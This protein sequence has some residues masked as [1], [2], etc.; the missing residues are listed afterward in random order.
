MPRRKRTAEP[1]ALE[2]FSDEE[3]LPEDLESEEEDVEPQPEQ[4][5]LA[6]EPLFAALLR[7]AT[8]KL[9]PGD[10]VMTDFVTH[11]AGPLSEL[12]GTRGAKGGDF[13][14]KRVQAGLD[15]EEGYSLDQSFRAHLINGLFP[16]LHVAHWL[17]IWG[18]PRLRYLNDQ[19]RRLFMAGYVLHDWLKLPDVDEELRAAGLSH[20]TVNAKQHLTL[21]ETL[22]QHWCEKLGLHAFL[23]PVGGVEVVLH[24]L[25]YIACNTQVKWGTLRNLSALPKLS[26]DGRTLDVCESLSRLADLITYVAP[27][28]R[29][30]VAHGGIHRE[31]AELSN[32]TARLV[33]HHV[34]DNRGVLTNL[35]HN[36]ALHAMR[37]QTR[38]PFL[39]A[40]SGVV[41]LQ[42]VSAPPLPD[43][44]TITEATIERVR[45]V[46][47]QRLRL[48]LTGFRRDG[49]G[50][51][52]ADYYDLFFDLS[53]QIRLAAAAIF[54]NIPPSKAP[55]AGKRFTKMR[56]GSWLD[57]SVDLALPDDTRVDQLA[58]WCYYV[59]ALLGSTAPDFDTAEFLMGALRLADMRPVFE[60][61]PR[62]NR[63]GGVGYHWYFM[64]GHYLKRH[65]GQDPAEWQEFIE[66]LAEQLA[67]KLAETFPALPSSRDIWSE[68]RTYTQQVVSI[69]PSGEIVDADR[70][71]FVAEL[72]HYQN[73]KRTGRARTAVCSLCSSPFEV[74]KQ[75]ETAIL[76]APMVYSNKLPLHGATAIRDICPICGLEMMLRQLLMNRSNAVGSRFENRQI[77]YLSFYPT[78][79]FSPETLEVFRFVHNRLQRISFTELRRQL[80]NDTTHNGAANIRLNAATLQRLEPLLLSAKELSG[81]ETD[82]YARMHFPENEPITFYFLGIPP[83]GRDAKDAEA[84]VHPAFLALLL[85]VCLDVKV[86]ASASPLPLLL[87]ADEMAETVFLDGPHPFVRYL[88]GQERINID[89]VL[90]CLQ[91][92]AIGYLIHLDAHSRQTRGQWD[93]RWSDIPPLA[94][95]LAADSAYACYY[96][97]QWQRNAGVDTV[98]LSKARQYMT[99]IA[100][101]GEGGKTMS[102]ARTLVELSRQFYRAR[103]YSS[104]SIL[105]PVAVVAKALLSA[106]RR[107]FDREGLTE[108]VRGELRAFM[109]R[110]QA[111]QA[112]GWLSP[113]GPEESPKEAA[114]RRE[115]YMRRFAEY[116]VGT[117]FY[118]TMRGDVAALRGR[119]LNLL[120]NAYE[121]IYRDASAHDRETA[122]EVDES[123]ADMPE[124]S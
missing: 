41:Y 106:D 47:A 2:L 44:A 14:V 66:Q 20:D 10:T 83:A 112:D 18:V 99:Y 81:S 39:Y 4:L 117:I 8:T 121:T 17:N 5:M 97:K 87:E 85:P 100:Y 75:Q 37:D 124:E 12:L 9:W 21:I 78:Y 118:D 56:D 102:H 96:L 65:P 42:H 120:R 43:S 90:P 122:V 123:E 92:L 76:F 72:D 27:T 35:I 73:A 34:A 88:I 77:R 46:G 109:E 25:I 49:K 7:Q 107:L 111:R 63:A 40:P 36:A 26:L 110:V 3:S 114:Q 48:S 89:Q 64:A 29:Q 59:E 84:W 68:L 93:Y 22:F 105:R 31:I 28:P 101:L 24:D 104:N 62:D 30:A 108:V 115:E 61:I 55:S 119:Q 13:V 60:A 23:H 82:R 71:P 53:E 91:R 94:R 15:V 86:V 38:V 116:F 45:Q 80:I 70:L 113:R 58:E 6:E 52:R 95:D 1:E 33:Y 98:P 16:V 57:D 74:T 32:N 19:A 50:L 54:K 103:G 11:V 79:F 67:G 69:G 51:K